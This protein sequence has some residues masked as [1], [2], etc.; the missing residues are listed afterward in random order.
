MNMI[1]TAPP[2]S[3]MIL[4]ACRTTASAGGEMTGLGARRRH[5]RPPAAAATGRRKRA[6]ISAKPTGAARKWSPT[7]HARLRGAPT[8]PVMPAILHQAWQE[9]RMLRPYRRWMATPCM[10]IEAS[11]PPTK[12]PKTRGRGVEQR[13][14]V[15]QTDGDGGQGNA[16]A[17]HPQDRAAAGRGASIP[18]DDA[19]D[20]GD[21][22]YR[23]EHDRQLC[24][25]ES[26]TCP[27]A[28]APSRSRWRSTGPGRRRTRRRRMR[29]RRSRAATGSRG[30]AAAPVDAPSATSASEMSSFH[31][32]RSP[33]SAVGPA[34]P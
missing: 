21:Q 7:P 20:A 3:R 11:T 28:P 12:N 15:G 17:Y 9:A 31:V 2:M 1:I 18:A 24:V 8:A 16:D 5:P 13:C 26:G 34:Q 19:A 23:G 14:A 22:R 25:A 32:C 33:P 30:A 6:R 4:P 10:F 29:A 27:A